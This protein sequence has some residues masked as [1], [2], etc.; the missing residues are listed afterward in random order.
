M[1][2][3][4]QNAAVMV[5]APQV[6]NDGM[7]RYEYLN[8]RQAIK[9]FIE[10]ANLTQDFIVL[11]IETTGL[12]RF[13]DT[14]ECFVLSKQINLEGGG[15]AVYIP[16]E[17]I[18][19]LLNIQIPLVLHNFKF[20]SLFL[21][22]NGVDLRKLGVPIIDTMLIH[23]IL[24]ENADHSLDSIIQECYKDPYKEVFWGKYKTFQ[25]APFLDQMAY[26]C[27]DVIYTGHLFVNFQSQLDTS[28]IPLE[29][30]EQTHAFAHALFDT[31]ARG[32]AVDENYLTQLGIEN[33]FTNNELLQ[34][35]NSL[36]AAEVEAVE[37]SMWLEELE[38]R[39]SPKG[40][41]NVK[42]PGFN[43]SSGAQ[44]Q[45]LIYGELGLQPIKKKS[46]TTKKVRPVLDD[47]AL[48]QLSGE[49]PVIEQLQ[50]YRANEKVYTSFIEGVADK[51]QDGRVY[52]SFNVNGTIGARISCSAPNLQQMPAEGNIRAMFIPDDGNKLISADFSSLEVVMAAHFSHDKN[53]LKIIYEG[54]S[55][56][57]ITAEALGLDRKIAKTLN[58]GMQYLCSPRKVMEIVGC[59]LKEAEQIHAQYW[60]TYKGEKLVIDNCKAKIDK[61]E[62]IVDI[63]GRLRRLPKTFEKE[64]QR[65]AAYRQ[66]YNF[67]LQSSGAACCN[68]A[69]TNTHDYLTKRS[70]GTTLYV[71]HDEVLI[72]AQDNHVT[73]AE[74]MLVTL[75]ESSAD[76]YGLTVPLK[77]VSSG[78]MDRWED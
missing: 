64:W 45:R 2:L 68:I 9:D 36:C 24:D 41:A 29:L 20:D 8:D 66:G 19:E 31:E 11:D 46:K 72:Q 55:K 10:I 25:E 26:A 42:K 57:D 50:A 62:S 38:K 32:I 33:R 13:K 6:L 76:H 23:H 48:S 22:R 65:E 69:F 15:S 17:Y 77:A 5:S 63:A 39:K 1:S 12:D 18:D 56:H 40:K 30:V 61:G 47:D 59:S 53:L 7:F 14:I 4:I 73:E 43:W 35:M 75:M 52:P 70:I 54:A 74:E 78:P 71:V 21:L 44:L 49:H 58:F 37:L 27:K 60:E 28:K 51:L 16:A 67:L 34:T 3:Q